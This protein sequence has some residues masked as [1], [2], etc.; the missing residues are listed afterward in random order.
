MAEKKPLLMSHTMPSIVGIASALVF[1]LFRNTVLPDT[2]VYIQIVA[3]VMISALV[4]S[5]TILLQEQQRS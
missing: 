2:P 5:V 4:S 1:L 3:I